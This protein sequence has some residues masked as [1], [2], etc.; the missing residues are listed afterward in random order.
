MEGESP[1]L[2]KKEHIEKTIK[3]SCTYPFN[4]IIFY[5]RWD[6]VAMGLLLRQV[7]CKNYHD[8]VGNEDCWVIN[9]FWSN[10]VLY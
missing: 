1:S 6:G 10:K 3:D 5:K 8:I 9:Q 4:N 7:P 2:R